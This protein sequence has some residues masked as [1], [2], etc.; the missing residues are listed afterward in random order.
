MNAERIR[1]ECEEDGF[2]LVVDGL[3]SLGVVRWRIPDPEAFY[4]HVK[5]AIGPWLYERDQAKRRF[6]ELS[7]AEKFVTG[8]NSF[9]RRVFK[10][11]PD[12]SGGYDVSDPKHPDFHSVHADIWD[13]REGK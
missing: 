2:H 4:D 1:I 7:R 8:D 9:T 10:C 11:D 5:A 13:A 12:E 6:E 3:P